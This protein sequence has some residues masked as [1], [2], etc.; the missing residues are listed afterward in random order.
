VAA[1]QDEGRDAVPA[2]RSEWQKA[3]P[4]GR[5]ERQ[6]AARLVVLMASGSACRGALCSTLGRLRS[7]V[8]GALLLCR[9]KF[10]AKTRPKGRVSWADACGCPDA[11]AP[12]F[13]EPIG[14]GRRTEPNFALASPRIPTSV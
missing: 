4:D 6:A 14:D 11:A 9:H 10:G 5:A 13:A 7:R 3:L 1:G 8:A 12:W 2:G